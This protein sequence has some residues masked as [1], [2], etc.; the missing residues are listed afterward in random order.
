MAN[1]TTFS[2]AVTAVTWVLAIDGATYSNATLSTDLSSSQI[3]FAIA[4]SIPANNSDLYDTIQKHETK[5]VVLSATDKIYVRKVRP[6]NA[7]LRAVL[8][9]R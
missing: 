2:L 5:S 1:T 4:T 6:R 3:A 7:K 8:V 9:S